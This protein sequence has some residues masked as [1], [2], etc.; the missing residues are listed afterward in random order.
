MDSLKNNRRQAG[1]V[2]ASEEM[3]NINPNNYYSQCKIL[4]TLLPKGKQWKGNIFFIYDTI[5]VYFIW[6]DG[7]E[8]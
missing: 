5:S 8:M 4:Q 2:P 7:E 3:T 6:M 1:V